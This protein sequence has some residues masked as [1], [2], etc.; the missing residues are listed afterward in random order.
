MFK[1][2]LELETSALEFLKNQRAN[3]KMFRLNSPG[4]LDA[5]TA[6]CNTEQSSFH[7]VISSLDLPTLKSDK[8]ST[9]EDR[10]QLEIISRICDLLMS[11]VMDKPLTDVFKEVD[12]IFSLNNN[13]LSIKLNGYNHTTR[14]EITPAHNPLDK[15][16]T[17]LD[18]QLFN[19][20][21]LNQSEE[22]SV[23]IY[24]NPSDIDGSFE[25]VKLTKF[26]ERLDKN[27]NKYEVCPIQT[28]ALSPQDITANELVKSAWIKCFYLY[29]ED[30]IKLTEP[31]SIY[32]GFDKEKHEH[33]DPLYLEN[34]PLIDSIWSADFLF[35]PAK[36]K[37][38][39]INTQATGDRALNLHI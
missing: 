37:L 20:I 10:H 3:N 8:I 7:I 2:L 30:N 24:F 28:L 9:L 15:I 17:T 5:F 25:P 36:N 12:F 23:K 34:Y 39:F 35:D 18:L 22:I 26:Y 16:N 38:M 27:S 6:L 4:L 1:T 29:G 21:Q 19:L 14:H 11:D 33:F 31:F 32:L 13:M